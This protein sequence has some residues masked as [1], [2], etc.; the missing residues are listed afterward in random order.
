MTT[1]YRRNVLDRIKRI[2]W[3]P[4]AIVLAGLL[5]ALPLLWFGPLPM[6]HDGVTHL[7]RYQVFRQQ[8]WSGDLCPRLLTGMNAGLGSPV[9]F[10]YGPVAYLAPTLLPPLAEKEFGIALAFALI[11]SGLAAYLWLQPFAGSKPAALAAMAYMAL[12]YHLWADFYVRCAVAE[13][14]AFVWMPLI[15]YFADRILERRKLSLAGFAGSIGLLTVTHLLTA[16]MF[17]PVVA[18]YV[19]LTSRKADRIRSVGRAFAGLALGVA[20]GAVYILPALA[21]EKNISIATLNKYAHYD[22]TGSL[23]ITGGALLHHDPWFATFNWYTTWIAFAMVVLIGVAFAA[24]V[25]ST[26]RSP[27]GGPFFWL[28]VDG[29]GLYMMSPPSAPVWRAIPSLAAFQFAWRFHT[30]L[31]VALAALLAMSFRAEAGGSARILACAVASVVCLVPYLHI[32]TCYARQT[33]SPELRNDRQFLADDMRRAWARWTEPD[34]LD[35]IA[36][37]RLSR[38]MPAVTISAAN[39]QASVVRW[40]PREIIVRVNSPQPSNVVL[41]Q[42]YYPG[43]TAAAPGNASATIGP[44]PHS[45]LVSVQTPPGNYDLRVALPFSD[46]ERAGLAVSA[47]ALLLLAVLERATWRTAA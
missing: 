11:A 44:S 9:M 21:S 30:V 37:G 32:L 22:L 26:P 6:A 28:L 42:F 5:L 19:L 2:T 34:L 16:V 38:S 47:A 15:L 27:L 13:V 17:L 39:G 14:W 24:I 4:L 18:A 46:A 43:W 31:A 10:I 25:R 8:F 7:N 36:M 20:L 12:P 1:W 29:A 41:R 45:G 3:H 23:F 40:R 35:S 33:M